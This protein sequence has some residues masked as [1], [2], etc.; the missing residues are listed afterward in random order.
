[1]IGLE[2]KEE[3]EEADAMLESPMMLQHIHNVGSR[4]TEGS[5]VEADG[6]FSNELRSLK[7]GGGE[8]EKVSHVLIISIHLAV[9]IF[10]SF[11]TQGIEG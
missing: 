4:I 11:L 10:L 6:S 1:V 3:K 8:R 7:G 2:D 9:F 5:L